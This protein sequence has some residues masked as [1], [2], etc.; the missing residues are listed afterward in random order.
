MTLEEE[1]AQHH[2]FH[3]IELKPGIVTPG[4]KSP[5]LMA[6]EFSRVFDPID[7]RGKSILDIGAWNGGFSIEAKRRGAA[8]VVA[9]DHYVWTHPVLRGRETFDLAV[10]AAGVEIEAVEQDL[11][12]PRLNLE[13]LGTFDI[14]LYMGV[15]YHLVDPIAA[16]REVAAR[17][18]DVLVVETY[19]SDVSSPVPQMI[20][21]PGGELCGDSTNWWGPNRK[22]VE[23]LLALWGFPSVRF[24]EGSS[25]ERGVFQAL[26]SAS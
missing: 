17:A 11:D 12:D 4:S 22:C 14:V 21:Y 10:K 7:V 1:I 15:F 5:S 2:W 8:R 23:D 20:F 26:R 18:A 13:R 25:S 19:L 16:T 24:A 6:L 3:S 9:L